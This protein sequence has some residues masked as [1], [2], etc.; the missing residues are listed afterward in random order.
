MSVL[1][2][3]I[4]MIHEQRPDFDKIAGLIAEGYLSQQRHPLEN[5]RILN[6]TQKTQCEWFWTPETEIFRGLIV[7]DQNQV[8]ARPFEKFFS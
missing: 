8:V 4:E 3:H 7:D 2:N 6:Y 5:Y 1:L